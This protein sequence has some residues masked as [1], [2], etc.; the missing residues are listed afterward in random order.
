[1][2]AAC[3][4]PGAWYFKSLGCALLGCGRTREAQAAFGRAAGHGGIVTPWPEGTCPDP[5]TA[6]Y[7][8]DRVT[9]ERYIA[10]HAK[11]L[12][13]G[14]TMAPFA[15]YYVGMRAEFEG[16][17]AD[18]IDAY[19]RAAA[20]AGQPNAHHTA[21]WAQYRLVRLRAALDGPEPAPASAASS[22]NSGD[23]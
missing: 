13:T 5:W 23:S 9:A 8:L 15:L 2:I 18:A 6:A 14:R 12:W 1:A 17:R 20:Y 16:R 11:L 3:T 22:A 19:E 7:F 4:S 10:H 21:H